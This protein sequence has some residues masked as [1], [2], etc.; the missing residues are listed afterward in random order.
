[1]CRNVRNDS[2]RSEIHGFEG[3]KAKALIALWCNEGLSPLNKIKNTFVISLA[4]PLNA[5]YIAF[6]QQ[7]GHAFVT[8]L[9][10][11]IADNIELLWGCW[12]T[13]G[14]LIGGKQGV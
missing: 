8:C 1:M 5:L 6:L 7:I 13:T 14:L 10:V 2:R 3:N 11:N 4:Y 12:L 9:K